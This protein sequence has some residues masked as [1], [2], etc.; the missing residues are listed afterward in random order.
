M[1]PTYSVVDLFAGCGGLTAGFLRANSKRGEFRPIAAVDFDVDS[2]ATYAANVGDHVFL[3]SIEDWLAGAHYPDRADVVLGGPPCQGFSTLGKQVVTDRRNAL[4]EQYVEAVGKM[5]P[6]FFV[7]ENVREFLKSEQF[8]GLEAACRSGNQLED[9]RIEHAVLDS[10][11]Y[12]APQRRRRAIVIGRRHDHPPLGQPT[13]THDRPNVRDAFDGLSTDVRRRE[14]PGR[15]TEFRG[16]RVPG[17]FTGDEVHVTRYFTQLSLNRYRSIP[18]GGNR[19]D[20]PY[21]LLAPCWRAHRTGSADVMGRM[22]WDKPSVTI[23]TEFYKP[24]KGRYLHP[25]EHRPITHLEAARLQGFPDDYKWFGSKYSIARQIGN[26]V[27]LQLGHALG[28]HILSALLSSW[29]SDEQKAA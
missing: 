18:P 20:I 4:W 19:F 26:A 13:G 5:R 16:E 27:P 10:S 22:S 1:K 3:G 12:G 9:Y 2:A 8:G 28:C 6:K 11:L 24:E 14:L 15:Y 17:P 21:H 29:S 25:T 7:L 23:R